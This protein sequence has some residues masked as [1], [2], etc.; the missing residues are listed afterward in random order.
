MEQRFPAVSTR[1]KETAMALL[2]HSRKRW[3]ERAA[4][5]TLSET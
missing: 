4:V 2:W 3:R 5:K 1:R